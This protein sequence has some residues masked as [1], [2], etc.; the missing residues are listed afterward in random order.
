MSTSF[1]LFK[2]HIQIIH[3]NRYKVVS[4]ISKPYSQV[5]IAFDDGFRGIY[6]H[7]Q[8]LIDHNIYPTIFIPTSLIGHPDYLSINELKEL[9]LLGFRIQSHAV[10]HRNLCNF[11]NAELISEL[12]NSKKELEKILDKD[13]DELCFPQ[14]YFSDEVCQTAYTYGY[15]LL[16]SSIPG[17]YYDHKTLLRRNF[18]QASTSL[19]FKLILQG[20]LEIL[21]HRYLR[22]HNQR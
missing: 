18:T 4:Q 1:E 7:R 20:G 15:K 8:W 5:Q 14:G 11:T 22:L 17:G 16:Y 9:S 13:I 12:V 2:K 10:S 6:E 3:N 21:Y 19:Q